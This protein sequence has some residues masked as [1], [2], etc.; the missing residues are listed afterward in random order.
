MRFEKLAG[1]PAWA[2][3]NGPERTP[4]SAS[5]SDVPSYS[6]PVG[7]PS[8]D[9]TV[10]SVLWRNCSYSPT[11]T[12]GCP[13]YLI[14][15]PLLSIM[16][17]STTEISTGALREAVA[18][19]VCSAG[20]STVARSPSL[21]KLYVASAYPPRPGSA[22]TYD[23]RPPGDHADCRVATWSVFT[24]WPVPGGPSH[25]P[26]T[27]GRTSWNHGAPRSSPTRTALRSVLV[28][29]CSSVQSYRA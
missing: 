19:R 1:V 17:E 12:P 25:A 4:K 24:D 27:G 5:R 23:A 26:V 6:T 11:P 18:K 22:T 9:R 28:L 7:T 13:M 10:R 20:Y 3:S 15:S 16:Y 29:P 2:H 21:A 14:V 8:G